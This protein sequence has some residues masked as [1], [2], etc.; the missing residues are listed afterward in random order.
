MYKIRNDKMAGKYSVAAGEEIPH[1]SQQPMI[2]S[3]SVKNF[4][5]FPTL[6]LRDFGKYNIVV[7][8]N[9]SG[10]TALLEALFLPG[11]GIQGN[12][13]YRTH[14]GM[15]I[16]AF[17]PE[18]N[19]Y[20]SIFD[21]FFFDFRTDLPIEIT[22]G[23]SYDNLRSVKMFFKPVAELPLLPSE[24]VKGR[25]S[26]KLFTV[27]TTDA[28]GKKSVQQ[29]GLH[30]SI[31]A[32]GQHKA[33]NIA[34]FTST[35][36]P[37]ASDNAQMLSNLRKEGKEKPIEETFKKIFPQ[38]LEMSP[39]VT[40]GTAEI[41]CKLKSL[42]KRCPISLVSHGFN[43]VL[44]L[45][46]F[47]ATHEGGVVLA[48]EIENGIHFRKLD[49]MWKAILDLCDSCDVQFFATTHSVECLNELKP[50]I[51]DRSKEF[52]LIRMSGHNGAEH[53]AYVSKGGD[54]AAALETETELR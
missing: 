42:R 44:T 16:P 20:E 50:F 11:N 17:S 38:I 15:V 29:L 54:F 31:I 5:C 32:A 45:L 30:G 22:L 52:R 9:G 4:R 1:D 21:D 39:E 18:R 46:L 36:M 47:I 51:Q 35:G 43:K 24:G 26:D 53:Q 33:A 34:Y 23:G 49:E 8:E 48:D 12:A 37:N 27:E 7:G 19:D 41:Y 28:D 13:I 14:R 25:I 3:L 40:S 10:K 6:E 2:Q